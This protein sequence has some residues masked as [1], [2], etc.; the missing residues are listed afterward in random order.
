MY[1]LTTTDEN[2][3]CTLMQMANIN[4]SLIALATLPLHDSEIN[5]LVTMLSEA[6]TDE[7][8]NE[9]KDML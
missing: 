9:L 6:L 1:V 8:R 7:Q 2:G 4:G 5:G 3:N